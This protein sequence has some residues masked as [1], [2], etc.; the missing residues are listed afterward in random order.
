MRKAVEI[1][2]TRRQGA[3]KRDSHQFA[4]IKVPLIVMLV[5]VWRYE[6]PMTEV[7]YEEQ[8]RMPLTLLT[9]A[10]EAQ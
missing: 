3:V 9:E 4:T 6:P 2:E 7:E 5:Q 1:N 10:P 8:V